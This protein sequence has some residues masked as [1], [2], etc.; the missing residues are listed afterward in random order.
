[1]EEHNTRLTLGYLAGNLPMSEAWALFHL[2]V[3]RTNTSIFNGMRRL[4]ASA[5]DPP[6]G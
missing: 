4:G 5:L 3:C 2:K 1:M 6:K